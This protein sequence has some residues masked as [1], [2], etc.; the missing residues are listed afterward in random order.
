MRL[1]TL[2]RIN[3]RDLLLI[4]LVASTAAAFWLFR[5]LPAGKDPPFSFVTFDSLTYYMPRT[6]Y[7][8][9][10]LR[11]GDMPLWN[12]YEMAGLPLL[13]TL[14]CGG[15]YPLNLPYLVMPPNAAWFVA[16]L[17]HSALAGICMFV[18]C[19]MLKI[20]VFGATVAALT[21]LFCSWVTVT[22]EFI[23]DE[24]RAT[25]LMPLVF[26][27]AEALIQR[28]TLTRCIWLGV[29][30]GLMLLSGEPEIFVRTSMI[31]GPY[32]LCRLA[33][34]FKAGDINLRGLIIAAACIAIAYVVCL[35]LTAPQ[36]MPTRELA[37]LGER[38]LGRMPRDYVEFP[39]APSAV[40]QLLNL[41]GP[42]KRTTSI[43]LVGLALLLLSP[44]CFRRRP[45]AVFFV[46][47]AIAGFM[48][49]L[50]KAT[51]LSSVYYHLPTGSWFRIPTR[52]LIF[53]VFAAPVAV[54]F[55]ADHIAG[56]SR[57]NQRTAV[58]LGTCA[59]VVLVCGAL[60][61]LM[62][63]SS[64]QALIARDTGR[65]PAIKD[66]SQYGLGTS[67]MVVLMFAVCSCLLLLSKRVSVR[68]V[69]QIMLCLL[70]PF[71]T[72]RAV[73][74]TQALPH[75]HYPRSVAGETEVVQFVKD[76][77]G[78]HRT[79]FDAANFTRNW[80]IPTIGLTNK[81][82]TVNGRD[83]L[84]PA[85]Y[86]DFVEPIREPSP[87]AH[88]PNYRLIM[89]QYNN[90]KFSGNSS[91]I[92]L[93][94]HLAVKYI[95]LGPDSRFFHVNDGTNEHESRIEATRY[96]L[97]YETGTREV[98]ENL[99]VL[100]RAYVA[101]DFKVIRDPA[102]ILEELILPKFDPRKTVILEEEPDIEREIGPGGPVSTT[103]TIRDYE[104]ERVVI[105]V[106]AAQG[107]F[108]VLSDLFFP[109]WKAY[110]DDVSVPVYRAN[111]MF[112]AVAVP[113]GRHV[114]TFV[115]RPASFAMGIAI[116]A[117]TI[118]VLLCCQ[119][120]MRKRD[121]RSQKAQPG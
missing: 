101:P 84:C 19:R 96:R 21:F 85:R 75:H 66:V 15:L 8:A 60:I 7:A 16:G 31:L 108:V 51:F 97:V 14:Q 90:I 111:Y 29:A 98:Y 115:Y 25:A 27:C 73:V 105:D 110:L 41:L 104:P 76:N 23:P 62:R 50:G 44:I 46:A 63:N 58:R 69:A 81:F 33:A 22:A 57:E 36:W 42:V 117:A 10:M 72:W 49:S 80:T 40:G 17:F 71:D 3:R 20:G 43:G 114:V 47:A 39:G 93:L 35:G 6:D 83:P 26:L 120:V 67:R 1:S 79:Y 92:G 52:L 107:G 99:N 2:T 121:G 53:F 38:P 11:G 28:R 68:I 94:D 13:A 64:M 70:I 116:S 65:I 86:L 109:G 78:M 12:P 102:E 30:L 119:V 37:G 59:A 18:F 82:F 91:A 32:V 95:V 88:V 34:R 74:T 112:R 118:L 61:V 113:A 4:L 45:M 56:M 106:E 103:A 77:A 87:W 24:H 9:S 55:A 100:P 48:L 5:I 54:G 89:P